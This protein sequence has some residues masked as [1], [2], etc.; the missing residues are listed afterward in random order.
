VP[1]PLKLTAHYTRFSY[2]PT[3]CCNA[4]MANLDDR[5]NI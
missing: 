3:L 2:F 5:T 1:A 4:A